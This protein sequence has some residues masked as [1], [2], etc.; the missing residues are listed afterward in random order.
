M[1]F[2]QI[3]RFSIIVFHYNKLR[4]YS[5]AYLGVVELRCILAL[6]DIEC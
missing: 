3:L 2:G 6:T 4:S 5:M 1:A